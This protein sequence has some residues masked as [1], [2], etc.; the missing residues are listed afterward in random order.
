MDNLLLQKKL[1]ELTKHEVK[2]KNDIQD[3]S[4]IPFKTRKIHGMEIPYVSIK[5]FADYKSGPLF[6]IKRH[7][8][9]Q[10]FPSHCHEGI[11]INYMYNG[12]CKQIINGKEH[13]LNCRQTLFLNPDT[14]HKI[15]P[16]GEHDILLNI[17]I[18]PDF[19]ITNFLNRF[20]CDSILTRFFVNALTDSIQQDTFLFFDSQKSD[21]LS[22]YLENLLCEWWHPSIIAQDIME[23]LLSLVMCELV[24]IYQKQYTDTTNPFVHSQILPI[25]RYVEENYQACTLS[26]TARFF[27]LNPNYLSNLLKKHTGLSYRELVQQKKLISAEQLLRSSNLSISEIAHMIGYENISFFYKK[28]KERNGCL[29]NEYRNF[30]T[31]RSAADNSFSH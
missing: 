7:S 14:I 1:F 11:E 6:S 24:I 28:F 2:Y 9:F 27:N 22:N 31:N 13:I 19:L 29:P 15:L 30:P 18:N 10:D 20:S 17:N 23:N 4:D 25:L 3:F 8:R 12:S 5:E 21:R 26:E 16:L